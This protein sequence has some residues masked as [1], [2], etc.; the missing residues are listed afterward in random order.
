MADA[1]FSRCALLGLLASFFF[2]HGS[3]RESLPRQEQAQEEEEQKASVPKK[4]KRNERET[5]TTFF[6]FFCFALKS[7]QRSEEES[8]NFLSF[9]STSSSTF[10]P[11]FLYLLCVTSTSR[12]LLFFLSL[13]F[14]LCQL[15]QVRKRKQLLL[16]EE[17]G[18]REGGFREKS[19]GT[20]QSGQL[21]CL[22][23]SM[24][25]LAAAAATAVTAGRAISTGPPSTLLLP[26]YSHAHGCTKHVFSI[27]RNSKQIEKGERVAKK[28]D[29]KTFQF[30]T[31]FLPNYGV[32]LPNRSPQRRPRLLCFP[33]LLCAPRARCW[34]FCV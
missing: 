10:S 11:F 28:G 33:R 34:S 1:R 2:L 25:S 22:F 26:S 23:F 20:R 4:G 31:S 3:A 27:T 21:P 30:S 12:V 13:F 24:G 29:T 19:C 17:A 15:H 16:Q 8:G 14:T 7:R 18:G 6:F 9:F 32:L 5:A